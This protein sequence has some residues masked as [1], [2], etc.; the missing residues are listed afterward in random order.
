[1]LSLI[2]QERY[3][4]LYLTYHEVNKIKGAVKRLLHRVGAR[5]LVQQISGR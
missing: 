4:Q 3:G 2:Q 1:M 5:K